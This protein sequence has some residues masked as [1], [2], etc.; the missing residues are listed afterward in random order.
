M[1]S[2]G[3]VGSG[4]RLISR[5]WVR[6]SLLLITTLEPVSGRVQLRKVP[7]AMGGR[8]EGSPGREL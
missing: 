4:G 7:L 8:G 1:E 5:A 6:L 3:E 2:W